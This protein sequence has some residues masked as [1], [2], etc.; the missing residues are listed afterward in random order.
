[1]AQ[2]LIERQLPGPR[3]STRSRASAARRPIAALAMLAL[4]VLGVAPAALAGG[5]AGD[6][7][8]KEAAGWG[9]GAAIGLPAGHCINPANTRRLLTTGTLPQTFQL[10]VFDDEGAFL[11]AEIATFVASA[12]N[13]ACPHDPDSP[14]GTYWAFVP[15]VLYV[16][17]H[18]AG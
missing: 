1:M 17:H 8:R 3:P 7:Q 10:Q 9:C 15:N 11:T 14:D 16:C 6:Q 18:R 12:D 4:L 5:A 13:R 2:Q